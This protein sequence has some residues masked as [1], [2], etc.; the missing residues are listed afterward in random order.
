MKNEIWVD[1][2]YGGSFFASLWIFYKLYF[3]QISQTHCKIIN[4]TKIFMDKIDNL[5]KNIYWG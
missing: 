3:I 2:S 1:A 5:N 4:L